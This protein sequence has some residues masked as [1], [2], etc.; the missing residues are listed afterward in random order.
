MER[1]LR[2]TQV[3]ADGG[4]EG[5]DTGARIEEAVRP[6]RRL[7]KQPSHEFAH[8]WRRKV[9]PFAFALLDGYLLFVLVLKVE[10][11]IKEAGDAYHAI[12]MSLLCAHSRQSGPGHDC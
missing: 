7:R 8:F 3:L 11:K 4:R 5:P 9:L 10:C 6:A 12:S 2:L 1:C